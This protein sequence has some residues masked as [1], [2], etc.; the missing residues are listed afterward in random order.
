MTKHKETLI[1]ALLLCGILIYGAFLR[2][3]QLDNDSYWIDESFT[4]MQARGIA[5]FWYPLLGSGYS[6]WKDVLIP[7][8]IAPFVK[9]FGYDHAWLLR[10][11]SALFGTASIFV[12]YHLAS[13]LFSRHVGLMFGFFMATCHWHIAW[14]QQVRGYAALIFFILLFFYF[15]ALFYKYGKIRF[16]YYAIGALVCGVLAKKFAILLLIPL[17]LYVINSR[18]Y[19]VY[20]CFIP[21]ALLALLYGVMHISAFF[22]IN[23]ISYYYFYLC[24]YLWADYSIFVVLFVIGFFLAIQYARSQFIVHVG[25]GLF[26]V[27]TL[28]FFS[29]FVFVSEKRYLLSITPFLFLYSAF[30]I[31]NISQK[32]SRRLV[33]KIFIFCSIVGIGIYVGIITILPQA[34][35]LLETY[36]PQPDYKTAYNK[37]LSMQFDDHDH[38]VS[39]N[40]S[41]DIIYLNRAEFAIPWS[42]T[43]R[44]DETTIRKESEYYSGARKLYGKGDK[45]AADRIRQ[46]QEKG[47]DVFVIFDELASQ[48]MN[49]DIWDIVTDTDK[50][51]VIGEGRDAVY[52]YY[53]PKNTY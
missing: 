7:Y 31:D 6:E 24:N 16:M 5:Q 2:F 3:Y 27:G 26:I 47:E 35:Y 38:I 46:F 25:I 49:I 37:I 36:T 29:S 50:K 13:V 19:R 45:T 15:F 8:I 30:F 18:N 28:C 4:L 21:L 11:P 14:S 12:G 23:P 40:P 10:L 44:D 34:K 32:F 43:G 41:L 1:I 39:A 48:R 20:L 33:W 17:I 52:I 51:Y 22:S 9:Y 53:F 42:L